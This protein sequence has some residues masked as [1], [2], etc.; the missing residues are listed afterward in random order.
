MRINHRPTVNTARLT[1]LVEKLEQ[2]LPA[3]WTAGIFVNCDRQLSVMVIND[4]RHDSLTYAVR[5]VHGAYQLTSRTED[6]VVETFGGMG[7]SQTVQ[8]LTTRVQSHWT[9][10]CQVA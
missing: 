10:P 6:V 2:A 7:I 8:A 4:S 9:I 3:G 1:T 5:L